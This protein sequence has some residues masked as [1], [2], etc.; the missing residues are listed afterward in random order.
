MAALAILRIQ[1]KKRSDA[2]S[3][4]DCHVNKAK[5]A[6]LQAQWRT[7]PGLGS[8]YLYQDFQ[9]PGFLKHSTLLQSTIPTSRAGA[10]CCCCTIVAV[11]I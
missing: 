1:Y 10:A 3:Q 8:H 11:I 4:C 9:T 2:H 5:Q 6:P 7:L